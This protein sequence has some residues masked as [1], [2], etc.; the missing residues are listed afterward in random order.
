VLVSGPEE[1]QKLLSTF[2]IACLRNQYGSDHFGQLLG[3]LSPGRGALTV[4]LHCD[5]GSP[6][7]YPVASLLV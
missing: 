7:F 5:L 1:A 6:G 4:K 2:L 3:N